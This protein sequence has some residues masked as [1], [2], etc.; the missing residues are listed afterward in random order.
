LQTWPIRVASGI[1]AQLDRPSGNVTGF[2]AWEASLA[3]KWLELLSE[4]A[5][6]LK[7]AAFMFN[8]DTAPTSA[9][10]PE[11]R[12]IAISLRPRALL[13]SRR[14]TGRLCWHATDNC[15]GCNKTCVEKAGRPAGHATAG[16]FDRRNGDAGRRLGA[17]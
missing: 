17:V 8:P 7:R 16:L 5:P 10:V 9:Y 4:I 11:R 14:C 12:G 3:G 1:V 13:A 15:C 2:A 6:G